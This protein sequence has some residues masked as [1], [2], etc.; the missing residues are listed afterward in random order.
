MTVKVNDGQRKDNSIAAKSVT[1]EVLD[2]PETPSA[3]GAPTVAGIPGSTDSVRVTWDEPATMGPAI[4]HYSLQYAISGSNDA[5]RRVTVPAGNADRSAV[6][7]GLTAG[8]RYDVQVRA[9]SPEG[10]SDWSRSGTGSPNPDVANRVPAFSGG[11][12]TFSVAENTPP[13]TDVGDLVAALD[14]DGDVLTYILEGDRRRLFRHHSHQQRGPDTDESGPELRGEGALLGGGESERRQGRDRRGQRDDQRDGR[15]YRGPGHAVRADRHGAVEHEPAGELGRPGQR[16]AADHRLRLPVQGCGRRQLDGGHEHDDH[17]DDGD[18]RWTHG[19][20]VLRR[21]GAGEERRGH[22]RLVESGQRSDER[23]RREQ[24]AR[25]H[26]GHDRHA[27]RERD[28]AGGHEHRRSHRGD[29]RRFGRHDH[30]QP[31]RAGRGDFR[32]RLDERPASHERRTGPRGDVHGHGR[33]RRRDG[34]D[35]H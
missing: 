6:I 25:V 20:H 12:R 24:P 30:L 34:H 1:I 35:A 2:R 14:P 19:E 18:D 28:I 11:S 9:E 32:H 31:R 33:R 21:G 17:G 16:R 8:T 13:G 10:H 15:Q 26:R 22:E 7:T 23:A 27:E 29:R 4:T 5:F 3:P